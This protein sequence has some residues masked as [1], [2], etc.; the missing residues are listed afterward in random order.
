MENR[1]KDYTPVI[2]EIDIP[3]FLVQGEKDEDVPLEFSKR[4][5]EK[6]KNI[7]L[8]IIPGADH[9]FKSYYDQEKLIKL[10]IEELKKYL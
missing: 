6:N 9:S 3:I 8:K 7:T 2:S 10:T 5:A 1:G 4:L